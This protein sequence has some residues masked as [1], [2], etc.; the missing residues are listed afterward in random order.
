MLQLLTDFND[1]DD[2]LARG[3]VEDAAGGDTGVQVG[4]R[5]LLHDD[6]EQEAWAVVRRIRNGVVAAEI[7]WSTWGP[8]GR[9]EE[10]RSGG[11]RIVGTLDLSRLRIRNVGGGAVAG[12]PRRR[13]IA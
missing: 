5:V 9:N 3:L 7:D 13:V 2:N 4:D 11:W 8:G 12:G 6:G 10:A 1:I